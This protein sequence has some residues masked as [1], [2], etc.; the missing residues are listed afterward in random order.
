MLD[1][2]GNDFNFLIITRDRDDL[3]N[4]PYEN[5]KV[6]EWNDGPHCKIFYMANNFSQFTNYKLVR[7]LFGG[8]LI[9]VI[10]GIKFVQYYL[11]SLFEIYFS[12]KIILLWKLKLL[13][14]KP[15]LV[16]PR[17][18]LMEGALSIKPFKKRIFLSTFKL[19]KLYKNI[20]WHASSE[21]EVEDIK[22]EF[23]KN[24][25]IKIALDVPN[26]NLKTDFVRTQLKEKGKLKILF[27][28]TIVPKKNLKF[29]IE[30]LNK[31]EGNFIFDIYGP[32]KDS[33]YWQECQNAIE[34]KVK[35]KVAYKGIIPNDRIHEIYPN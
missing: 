14:Q 9:T 27:I 30:V 1:L 15:I 10:K 32:I 33:K 7:H 21:Y 25:K 12:T 35:N 2:L 26:Y 20:T 23:G 18:E 13:P 22:R 11:N 28:S 6:N 5:I 24:E 17:G 29:A 16:A 8:S 3:E 19:L 34:D 31:I 4:K